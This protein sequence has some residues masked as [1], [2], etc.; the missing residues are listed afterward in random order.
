MGS[1]PGQRTAFSA[2]LAQSSGQHM[3]GSSRTKQRRQEGRRRDRTGSGVPEA[4]LSR[5]HWTF[6]ARSR[7][8]RLKRC[9]HDRLE[10]LICR[11]SLHGDL[12]VFHADRFG[13]ITQVEREWQGVREELEMVLQHREA[14]PNFQQ[15]LPQVG[16]IQKDDQWKTFFL[17]GV[18]MDCRENARRCPRTMQLLATIPGCSTAF[19]S[20]LSPH[21]HIPPHR[22]AWAGVLR[23]HLALIV[24]E[25]RE[26]CRIRIADQIHT[27]EEGRCLVFDDT[28]NHQVWNDTDGYRVVL[29]V[30]FARP[31]RWPV[32]VLNNWILNLAAL[33]PFL[34][35]ANQNQ[36]AAER[37]FWRRFSG[38]PS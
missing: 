15:I 9:L 6:P 16:K 20:I 17:K 1:L 23:L 4:D 29:F 19:F 36:Q 13:W 10:W 35:E 31:L 33:A 8:T 34:R 25:P 24:P 27:W 5:R 32:S 37:S 7:R 2:V 18:G 21:K 3:G 12:P 28:Y 26:Q 11:A 22:G 14:M 38:P 30:D